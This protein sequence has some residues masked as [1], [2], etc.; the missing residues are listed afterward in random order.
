MNKS[1][2]TF[3]NELKS[4]RFASMV[5]ESAKG[6]SVSN[7]A[8]VYNILKPLFAETD[9]IEKAYF[10]FLDAK[11]N[12]LAIEN[13]F[14]G[15]IAASAIYPREIVKRI[16]SL[17]AN[18]FV[19]AHNHPSGDTNPSPEDKQ[20]TKKVGLA[21]ASIDVSLHDH[22][23]IGDGY[24][25]MADSGWLKKVS[26]EFNNILNNGNF[27]H[28]SQVRIKNQINLDI[29]ENEL[30]SSDWEHN[31]IARDLIWWVHLFNASFFKDNPVPL[32]VLT[33]EKARV[34][35]LGHYGIGR[36]SFAVKEQINLNRLHIDRPLWSILSTLLHEM[37][38]SYEYTYVPENKRTKSWY[39]S[40]AFRD[41]MESFGIICADN[42]CHIGLEAN[43]PFVH[44]LMQ[45]GVSFDEVPGF[46]GNGN[47]PE[48]MVPIDTKPKIKGKS[49]LKKWT[50]GC[51]IV[52]IGTKSFSARCLICNQEFRLDE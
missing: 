23:I 49:K 48:G 7:S 33:F 35:N 44:I 45:H 16:I 32:P 28:E 14:S 20:I 5:K 40:K 36:N 37:V 9:D 30:S 39:H 24:H 2:N 42:G 22:I 15:T 31:E 1:Y 47:S 3:W 6:K 29:M 11:N 4:G 34:N 13:L 18:A 26:R 17:K 52:R 12:I 10:I 38:H 50:C 51:Q 46:S 27:C 41:K 21:A 19:M 8:E 25:S 43:G